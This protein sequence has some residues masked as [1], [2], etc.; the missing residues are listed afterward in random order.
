M[1][2]FPIREIVSMLNVSK[3]AAWKEMESFEDVNYVIS[4]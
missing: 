2:I 1:A 4:S 3:F